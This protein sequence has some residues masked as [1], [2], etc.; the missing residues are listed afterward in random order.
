MGFHLLLSALLVLSRVF[1]G[2]ALPFD[3]N[4]NISWGN[5]NVKSLNNGEEIQLSLDKFSGSGIQSKQSYSSGSFKMRIKLPS[6]DSAGVVTTFYLHSHTSNHDELDFEFLGNREGKPYTLQT[7]VFANGVGDREQRI[8][9]WFDP[10]ANFHEY[11]IL[12]NSHQTVFFVD[13]IPIRVYKNN[14]HRGVGYPSQPM[15]SE[16][17]IWNGETW[18]TDNG[19]AKINWSNSPFTAQFQGFNIE[20]CTSSNGIKCNST[21]FWWNS[22]QFWKLNHSQEKSYKDIR[23][24][25]MVYDYCKDTNRFQTTPECSK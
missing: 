18:A 16:A 1:E 23:S 10:T 11:S 5:N 6:K 3:K 17:T 25:H 14:S 8:Q 9:L 21:K 24:K 20:G 2:Q 12:W 4:Y 19:S 7:N 22:K 15:Q 13:E